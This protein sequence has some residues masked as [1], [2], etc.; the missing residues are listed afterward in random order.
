[1]WCV[2]VFF[3]FPDLS[4]CVT[5][6]PLQSKDLSVSPPK[7]TS[8]AL[9]SDTPI[10]RRGRLAN[11]AATIGSWEDDLSHPSAKQN[12]AQEQP[13]TTCLSKLSTT[14]E[15][16]ARI[17]SSSVKQEAASCSQRLVEASINKP[18]N[19]K[20]AVSVWFSCWLKIWELGAQM[21]TYN[22]LIWI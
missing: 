1:M 10:G 2:F 16:S 14:S 6:S 15:A 22:C 21:L 11:L 17:N 20:I 19:S 4:E 8:N 13:G 5:L 7:Q 12:N 9:A 3:F 18:A